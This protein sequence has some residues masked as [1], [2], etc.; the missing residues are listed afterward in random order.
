MKRT[1]ALARRALAGARLHV[2]FFALSLPTTFRAQTLPTGCAD[3]A[4]GCVRVAPCRVKN[5]KRTLYVGGLDDDVDLAVLRA[6]FIPFGEVSSYC[7]SPPSWL[8][9]TCVCAQVIEMSTFLGARREAHLAEATA[10]QQG[11][12]R[13]GS[14]STGVL[15]GS[16]CRS[17]LSINPRR[18]TPLV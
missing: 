2:G 12:I 1:T 14:L 7:P 17:T 15:Y 11:S 4:N 13:D 3:Y 6:A 10:R 8:A 18:S 5:D 9:E 16:F